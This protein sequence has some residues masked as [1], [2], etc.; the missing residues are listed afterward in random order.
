MY[1]WLPRWTPTGMV[2]IT[3]EGLIL[4][5]WNYGDEIRYS[6]LDDRVS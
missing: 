1:V 3:E 5:Y 2:Y 4:K 6:N